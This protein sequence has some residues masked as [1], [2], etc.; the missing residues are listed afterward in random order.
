MS[1]FSSSRF[2]HPKNFASQSL[3]MRGILVTRERAAR[4]DAGLEE[5]PKPEPFQKTA[6]MKPKERRLPVVSK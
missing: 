3:V 2:V 6:K 1:S 5:M 4:I